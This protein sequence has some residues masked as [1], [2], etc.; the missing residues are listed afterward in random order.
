MTMYSFLALASGMGRGGA[1]PIVKTGQVKTC[2][3]IHSVVCSDHGHVS[4]ID[5]MP[6]PYP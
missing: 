3:D 4:D 6:G 1:C 2:Y 5:S